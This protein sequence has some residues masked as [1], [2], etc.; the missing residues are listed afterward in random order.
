MTPRPL[1]VQR[2]AATRCFLTSHANFEGFYKGL[3]LI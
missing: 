1:L 3:F 2:R